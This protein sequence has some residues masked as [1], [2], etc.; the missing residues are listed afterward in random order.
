MSLQGVNLVFSGM[1]LPYN[2]WHVYYPFSGFSGANLPS[3]SGANTDASGTLIQGS[4]G[5][6]TGIGTF[7]N[8]LVTINNATGDLTDW[9]IICQFG[10]SNNNDGVLFSSLTS[11]TVN[12][13]FV[14]GVT[15]SN[16]L[17]LE[18]Y[19]ENGPVSYTSPTILGNQNIVAVSKIGQSLYFDYFNANSKNTESIKF[20]TS[21]KA[22]LPSNNL[23]L[24]GAT[25]TPTYFDGKNFNGYMKDFM[26]FNPAL[27]PEEIKN[28]LRGMVYSVNAGVPSYDTQSILDVGMNAIAYLQPAEVRDTFELYSVIG[29]HT[30]TGSNWDADFDSVVGEFYA[31][32]FIEQTGF[33]LFVNGVA[34]LGL[35]GFSVSGNFYDSILIPSG[36]FFPSGMKIYAN[37]GYNVDDRVVYDLNPYSTESVGYY[38]FEFSHDGST[39]QSFTTLSATQDAVYF[40]G[41]KLVVGKD[42]DAAS[43]TSVRFNSG[44]ALYD[45]AT[46]A[47]WTMPITSDYSRYLSSGQI[48]GS[49]PK[50]GRRT[51][52]FWF[53]GV[54][55]N[56]DEFYLEVG[57]IGL[58]NGTGVFGDGTVLFDNSELFL[59]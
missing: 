27:R 51:S 23:T 57:S 17:Y 26:I 42:Y 18:S 11:G 22:F 41:V 35:T 58:M 10:K 49:Y 2:L 5:A 31:R 28:L 48:S 4:I 53:N 44:N 8:T 55:Q 45:G 9:T 29:N 12:S 21:I 3:F 32:D 46:G 34:Q 37:N 15:A 25:N 13:G 20:E 52:M 47:I 40:N 39:D 43:A 7:N 50:F 56:L 16:R 54:R 14:F 59:F 19:A 6:T 38:D 24:G 36:D 33:H 30:Y 1:G